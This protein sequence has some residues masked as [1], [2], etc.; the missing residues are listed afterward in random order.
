MSLEAS[1]LWRVFLGTAGGGA[2]GGGT[3][4]A[5]GRGRT[6]RMVFAVFCKVEIWREV[7]LCS[8]SMLKK[9]FPRE[10]NWSEMISLSLVSLAM[11]VVC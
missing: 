7:F 8:F 6:L 4:L 9:A 5:P 3:G 1:L 10:A 2:V 11:M